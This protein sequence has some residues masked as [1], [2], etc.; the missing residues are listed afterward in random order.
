[1]TC[2]EVSTRVGA[3]T[4]SD[5]PLLRRIEIRLH[6]AMCGNCR[7]FWKQIQA[8]D[9]GLRAAI[10]RPDQ[11]APSDLEERIVARVTGGDAERPKG[12]Q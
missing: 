7:R 6:L 4:V 8:L 3:G 11:E 2:R 1:M 9:R 10:G 5:E 12:P